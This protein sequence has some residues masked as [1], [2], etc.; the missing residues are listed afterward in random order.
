MISTA[1]V[2]AM[3]QRMALWAGETVSRLTLVKNRLDA[4]ESLT[5]DL[6]QMDADKVGLGRVANYAPA[7]L[8][9]AVNGVNNTSTM[10]PRRTVDFAEANIY[11]PIGDAFAA[12]AARLP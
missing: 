6:N 11:G 4:L 2:T 10:T 3:L 1:K 9:Q 8:T 12:A 5:R 7:T